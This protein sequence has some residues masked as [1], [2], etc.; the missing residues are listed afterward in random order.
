MF[1]NDCCKE[2]SAAYWAE[3]EE[4][5][6][7]IHPSQV[8]ERIVKELYE[9]GTDY[10]DNDITFLDWDISGSRVRVFIH[11]SFFG[12]FDYEEN[13]FQSTPESRLEEVTKDFELN[14]RDWL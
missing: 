2:I 8:K 7:G 9:L 4:M 11:D 3:E 13:K 5:K 1:D 12:I 6:L 14:R 10:T